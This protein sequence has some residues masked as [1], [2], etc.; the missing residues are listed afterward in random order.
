MI[1]RSLLACILVLSLSGVVRPQTRAR[2]H[3]PA[4]APA[5]ATSDGLYRN[6]ALGFAYK[7]PFGWVDRTPDMQPEHSDSAKA[8]VLLAVFERPPQASGD[9]VNSAVIIA[10]ESL[11]AYPGLKT[12]EDYFGALTEVSAAKG[13]KVTRTPEAFEVDARTLVRGDFSRDL[14]KFQMRQVSLVMLARGSV[15]SF[16]FLA[17]SDEQLDTLIE[18]LSFSAAKPK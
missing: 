15:V 18:N 11:A 6:P 1:V 16:T 3:A 17:G 7:I 13:F 5:A 14:G 2:S 4:G 8:Q 9:T 10:T 12:A